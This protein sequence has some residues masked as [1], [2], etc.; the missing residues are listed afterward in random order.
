MTIAQMREALRNVQAQLD[1]ARAQ[2]QQMAMREDATVE[3]M[4][5]CAERV[6]ALA[7]RAQLLRG[8]L[9]AAEAQ[10]A[11]GAQGAGAQQPRAL[12]DMLSS[13]EYARAFVAAVRRGDTP[14]RTAVNDDNRI[15]YDALTIAGGSPAGSDGGYL[16]PTEMDNTIHEH[17]RALHPLSEL[18]NVEYVSSN[19]G[20]RVTD[21][22]PTRGF[23]KLASE[24]PSAG[25]PTDDQPKFAQVSYALSTY[26]LRLPVSNELLSDEVAGV[27]T[28]LG[29]WF[30]RKLV[31]THNTLILAELNKLSAVAITPGSTDGATLKSIKT[32]L[33][34]AL[35]PAISDLAVLITNQDGYNYLD[36]LADTNGRPLLQ[37][38]PTAPGRTLLAGHRIVALSNAQLPSGGDGAKCPLYIG[39]G[40]QYMTL[41]ARSQMEL[42]STD[43]GGD[44]WSTNSTELRGIVRLATAVYDSAA[45]VKRE[46][47]IG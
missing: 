29:R 9:D 8:E 34:V 37:P 23:T 3:E 31:I 46:I 10:G 40:E 32:V 14:R 25:V 21:T 43:V 28:Y 44:A 6:R 41:F 26:G 38:D 15:L 24:V 11:R 12:R 45:M 36:G 35:D 16:V 47:T 13:N 2:A 33:N 5:Q 27:M 22:A 4:Q 7:T 19:T 39:S 1:E 18:V 30:A 42:S 20:W 17:M